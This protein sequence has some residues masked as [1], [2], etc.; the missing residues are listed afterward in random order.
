MTSKLEMIK[1]ESTDGGQGS[2]VMPVRT[3]IQTFSFW[4]LLF[5][6]KTGKIGKIGKFGKFEPCYAV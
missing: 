6:K 2:N 1:Q 3:G 4:I 5:S